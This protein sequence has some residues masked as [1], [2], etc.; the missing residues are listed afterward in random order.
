[1]S[2]MMKLMNDLAPLNRVFCSKD[3]DR[4]V[5]YLQAI[6]PFKVIPFNSSQEFNG[7]MIPPSWDV[8]EAK[9]YRNGTLIY[10]GMGTPLSV[11][12]MS[13]GFKGRVSLEEL[14]MHLHYDHRFDDAIPYHFRQEY[15]SW[16]RDWGL[17]VPRKLYKNLQPGEYDV[18][19]D[20]EE[21]EGVLK[22]L[23]Y[24]HVGS[25]PYRIVLAAHLDHPA[26]ANDG[27][28][29][30]VVGIEVMRRLRGRKTK[31]TYILVLHQ[32]IIGAEY[33]L[34]YMDPH[35]RENILEG[36]FLEMLGTK[37]PLALQCSL[38]GGTN[39]ERILIQTMKE[40]SLVH[41]VGPYGSIVV[42]GEYIWASY[43][44]QLSSLSR[45]PYPEYHCDRDNIKIISEESLEQAV[46]VIMGTIDNLEASPLVVKKFT[47]N[48]CV[49]N[50]A[51]DLYIDPG[52]VAFGDSTDKKTDSLRNLME[53]IPSLHRPTSVRT[54]AE[55]TGMDDDE[56]LLYLNRWA[57]KGLLQIV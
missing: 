18:V 4:S 38:G 56:I 15:R 13:A 33:Y 14:K 42:N 29:G 24:S 6:L 51:Y 39:I 25:L 10:E 34:G 45:F 26:Q 11:I 37:T 9:V 43:G 27:L 44:V 52:Q 28:S 40:M 16:E 55:A 7:W 22:I 30:C 31:F 2:V 54:L 47:G 3:Y 49:S 17:C 36:V 1:M 48:I 32:E 20:T 53:L 12:A 50:P 19:I 35:V 23:E 8:R 21:S 57:D 46:D 5:A 41:R